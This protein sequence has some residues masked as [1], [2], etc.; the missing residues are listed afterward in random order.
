MPRKGTE[1]RTDF[2][3]D[4][5]QFNSVIDRQKKN[6]KELGGAYE[7]ATKRA[8]KSV[9]GLVGG[10]GKLR[11]AIAG[12][13]VAG[14]VRRRVGERSAFAVEA[15]QLLK[16]FERVGAADFTVFQQQAD[17]VEKAGIGVDSYFNAM[18]K[19]TRQ[20]QLA[21]NGNRQ[22]ADSFD[23]LFENVD[24]TL[25]DFVELDPTEQF[26]A[27]A[28]AVSAHDDR[29]FA[30]SQLAKIIED[31]AKK[32][33]DLFAGG[34][35]GMI[36]AEAQLPADSILTEAEARRAAAFL[37]RERDYRTGRRRELV[38]GITEGQSVGQRGRGVLKQVEDTIF[39]GP[40][41]ILQGLSNIFRD[42]DQTKEMKKQTEL[43]QQQNM[44]LDRITNEL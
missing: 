16:N 29:D 12:I 25:D 27:L 33:R 32:F 21:A 17:A 7:K 4:D 2:T 44:R 37:D 39:D 9:T 38:S 43:L 28:E 40:D 15:D 8:N 10:I 35:E 13:A 3:G 23:L 26:R 1:L 18:N 30:F 34:R 36:R 11:K 19:A 31:D 20:A 5:R 42:M 6:A 24:T 41:K 22:L 14:I